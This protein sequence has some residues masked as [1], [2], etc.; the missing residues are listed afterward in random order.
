M[1]LHDVSINI[2]IIPLT[3]IAIPTI[4]VKHSYT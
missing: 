1:I 4:H 3:I 2:G